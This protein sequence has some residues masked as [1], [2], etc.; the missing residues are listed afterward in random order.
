MTRT[1]WMSVSLSTP[2]F[3]S[4]AESMGGMAPGKGPAPRRRADRRDQCPPI[5]V[6]PCL[7]CEP[8]VPRDCA[9]GQDEEPVALQVLLGHGAGAGEARRPEVALQARR[10]C[11][12]WG[13]NHDKQQA[14]EG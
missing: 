4:L 9:V 1:R 7:L 14:G 6:L 3:C 2:A 8:T 5:T 11:A 13:V 10:D 12:L